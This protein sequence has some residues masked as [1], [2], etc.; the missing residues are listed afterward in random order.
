MEQWYYTKEQLF[1][2]EEY[3]KNENSII[4][5]KDNMRSS[6]QGAKLFSC[7]QSYADILSVINNTEINKK[8]YYEVINGNQKQ[9]MKF[10]IDLTIE[11]FNNLKEKK[12]IDSSFTILD[13]TKKLI[14]NI[15]NILDQTI[16]YYFEC[17]YQLVI[18]SSCVKDVKFSSHL[19]I[20]GFYFN[21]NK[22]AKIL[23]N[24]CIQEL[25]KIYSNFPKDILMTI[26]DRSV[27]SSFQNFRLPNCC[28][29]GKKNFKKILT[30]HSDL[31]A[32]ITNI[33]NDDKNVSFEVSL[34]PF[35]IIEKEINNNNYEFKKIE[36]NELYDLINICKNNECHWKVWY[37]IG[38]TIYNI[39][40]MNGRDNEES[41]LDLFHLF[42]SKSNKYDEIDTND[43]W[44]SLK[45]DE[46][47]DQRL[48][49]GSL[50][51]MAKESDLEKYKEWYD[52][53]Y[54]NDGIEIFDLENI[55]N[56]NDL[57]NEN[58][59]KN[60]F[61]KLKKEKK[62]IRKNLKRSDE[63]LA[64]IFIKY[65]QNVKIINNK[66]NCFIYDDKKQLWLEKYDLYIC[67][68]IS[69]TLEKVIDDEIEIYNF[70]IKKESEKT[71]DKDKDKDDIKKYKEHL[72]F[73]KQIK[74]Y[75]LS[76]SG[77]NKILK[78]V[79]PKIED[80]EFIN[81]V[82]SQNPD[83]L[84]IKNGIINLKTGEV[85][86]RN[87]YDYFSFECPVSYIL[88]KNE[89][90]DKVDK[91]FL[92]V[93][94]DDEDLK[95]YLQVGLGYCL[96]GHISERCFYVWHG[97]GANGKS[98]ICNLLQLIMNKFYTTTSKD[99]FIKSKNGNMGQATPHLIPLIGSRLATFSESDE[100]E[101]LDSAQIKS[102]TGGE[103]ITYRKLYCEASE[104][105]PICKLILQTNHKPEIDSD[106]EA[107]KDRI[108]F[109]PF[110]QRFTNN[111]KKDEK[112]R[113]P[114]LI[115]ELENELLDDVFKWIIEGSKKWYESGFPDC[116]TI[117]EA[118]QNYI[119]ENDIIGC[120]LN[121]E[122]D[123][124]GNVKISDLYN[125]FINWSNEN[126]VEQKY[127]KIQFSKIM[128]KKGYNKKLT[129]IN[130]ETSRYWIGLDLK[131]NM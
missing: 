101:K 18:C 123:N 108:K 111:P 14:G 27:Y 104:F 8:N 67:N 15:K 95:N 6:K 94:K 25:L 56:E 12:L 109:Y 66:G 40:Y 98:T 21:N 13:F 89:N 52:E 107:I 37:K 68:Q 115:R 42:S 91:F 16:K 69:Q 22:E 92:D 26:I 23:Y 55:E 74:N 31:D 120:F 46:H 10:D 75:C 57:E 72:K 41:Y 129:T 29:Y 128:I 113:N 48:T 81:I 84:P 102:L 86:K 58:E 131:I 60:D 80:I 122:C 97:I 39:Y 110:N 106:D 35:D 44:N 93:C 71:Q 99:I 105:K 4:I 65:N 45:F 130:G 73:L 28:K 43:M 20:K 54:D 96:T 32:F 127:S 38:Q 121:E 24:Y 19:I 126:E 124:N 88:E 17:D 112:K 83:I 77:S 47:L 114:T 76:T 33:S 30:K 53:Y 2:S 3:N 85:R 117:E 103:K 50:R 100:N 78:K 36:K 118:K 90:Y 11:E 61:E 59:N 87:K 49:L 9:K 63:G 82:N 70:L 119:N 7:A 1:K 5:S 116:K 34:L 62:L 64:D 125:S 79:I 51:K